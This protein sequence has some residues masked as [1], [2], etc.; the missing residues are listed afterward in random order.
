MKSLFTKA[1]TDYEK[2][3]LIAKLGASNKI[4]LSTDTTPDSKNQMQ[5]SLLFYSGME[6]PLSKF[7]PS[8]QFCESVG[9]ER[10]GKGTRV[11]KRL[12]GLM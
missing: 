4:P 10:Q 6:T 12:A 7:Q 5:V 11:P 1:Y 9:R 8:L 3:Y 2:C